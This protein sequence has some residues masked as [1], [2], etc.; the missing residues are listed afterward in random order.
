MKGKY[1]LRSIV[2]DLWRRVPQSSV[3]R[4]RQSVQDGLLGMQASHSHP[5]PHCGLPRLGILVHWSVSRKCLSRVL[6]TYLTCLMVGSLEASLIPSGFS[7]Q[8]V[9]SSTLARKGCTKISSFVESSHASAFTHGN[10]L[11]WNPA[12]HYSLFNVL[13]RAILTQN[14]ENG[15]VLD[16]NQC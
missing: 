13:C 9:Q 2:T 1:I 4:E 10:D 8:S 12:K 11:P 3:R 14:G 15:N 16:G 6:I 7:P 5:L